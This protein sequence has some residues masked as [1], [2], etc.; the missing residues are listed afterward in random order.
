MHTI[1]SSNF[2][3]MSASDTQRSFFQSHLLETNRPNRDLNFNLASLSNAG[4]LIKQVLVYGMY[5][6]MIFCRALTTNDQT[7]RYQMTKLQGVILWR[8]CTTFETQV[9]PSE[10]TR[11]RDL[12]YHLPILALWQQIVARMTIAKFVLK[13][14][15]PGKTARSLV[16]SLNGPW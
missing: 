5:I 3:S 12:Q 7:K 10:P 1:A 6:Y 4:P 15:I 16:R 14:T 13:R 9:G 2:R 11:S 8:L